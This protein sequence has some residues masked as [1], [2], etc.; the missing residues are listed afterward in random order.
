M[1]YALVRCY[2]CKEEFELVL[3]VKLTKDELAGMAVFCDECLL[4]IRKKRKK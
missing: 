2:Q 4:A 3:G 1:E